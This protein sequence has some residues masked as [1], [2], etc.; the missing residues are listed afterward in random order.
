MIIKTNCQMCGKKKA[1]KN[2]IVFVTGDAIIKTVHGCHKCGWF[3]P[4]KIDLDNIART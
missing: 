3:P 1:V 4:K 2:K